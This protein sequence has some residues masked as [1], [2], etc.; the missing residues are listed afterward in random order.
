[1]AEEESEMG[2]GLGDGLAGEFKAAAV[3]EDEGEELVDAW[4]GMAA[5]WSAGVV[6]G[7]RARIWA[8]APRVRS[9]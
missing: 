4:A 5:D 2:R 9:S 7:K 1:M 3:G 8:A 6:L